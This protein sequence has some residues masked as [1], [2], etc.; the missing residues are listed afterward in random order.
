[1]A[2]GPPKADLSTIIGRLH[3]PYFASTR[4]QAQDA[5]GKLILDVNGKPIELTLAEQ[6]EIARFGSDAGVLLASDLPFDLATIESEQ[7][8]VQATLNREFALRVSDKTLIS[9][10]GN[11]ISIVET[12]SKVI[13]DTYNALPANIRSTIDITPLVSLR[14]KIIS[15]RSKE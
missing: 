5:N 11:L 2:I 6:W 8:S 13:F 14:N 9:D 1:M 10:P 3:P 7:A 4:T 15:I 12:I